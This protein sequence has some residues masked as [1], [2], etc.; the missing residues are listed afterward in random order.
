MSDFLADAV[1]AKLVAAGVG[2]LDTD[3]FVHP[4]VP[5]GTAGVPVDAIFVYSSDGLL[6]EAFIGNEKDFRRQWV[7]VRVRRRYDKYGEG[8]GDMTTIFN[9]LH[10]RT[11]T[12]PADYNFV[13]CRA[14]TSYATFVGA[15][16]KE[17][18]LNWTQRFEIGIEFTNR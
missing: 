1:V 8:S 2:T 10:L 12:L 17:N 16:N 5:P 7:E 3:I 18:W 11:L 4:E 6:P 9:A 15:L 14:T 13:W